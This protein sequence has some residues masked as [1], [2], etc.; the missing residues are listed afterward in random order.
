MKKQ[1]Y[2]RYDDTAKLPEDFDH[3]VNY[4]LVLL[5]DKKQ[6]EFW[7][8]VDGNR[9]ILDLFPSKPDLSAESTSRLAKK[10]LDGIIPHRIKLTTEELK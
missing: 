3:E 4:L 2:L 5:N 10:S 7:K 9:D 8:F 6:E 1:E